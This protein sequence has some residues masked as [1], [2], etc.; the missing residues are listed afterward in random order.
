MATTWVARALG[1]GGETIVTGLALVTS[2]ATDVVTA[3]ALS[4]VFITATIVAVGHSSCIAVAFHTAEFDVVAVGQRFACV[5]C[6]WDGVGWADAI[7]S[8]LVAKSSI[9]GAQLAVGVT[10]VT[11]LALVTL[12]SDDVGFA[13]TLSTKRLALGIV[14]SDGTGT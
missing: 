7:S 12:A 10:I 1:A 4:G 6:R 13:W 2:D 5:A 14:T 9:A 8:D 11:G 3:T